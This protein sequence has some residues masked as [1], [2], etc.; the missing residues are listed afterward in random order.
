M[1]Y[2]QEA[3]Q[4]KPDSFHFIDPE[5]V[6]VIL[7]P[8]APIQ[9][10]PNLVS[11]RHV[12]KDDFIFG[13][14]IGRGGMQGTRGQVYSGIDKS[15]GQAVA[16][17]VKPK[18]TWVHPYVIQNEIKVVQHLQPFCRKHILCF[19]GAFEDANS[20]YLVTELLTGYVTLKE[21]ICNKRWVN[22]L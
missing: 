17:K 6:D 18:G 16:I 11:A 3:A 21:Y 13:P 2:L 20:Y 15:T 10:Q 22:I 9:P 4:F 8:T 1:K 7:G 5:V 14:L 12:S 19:V